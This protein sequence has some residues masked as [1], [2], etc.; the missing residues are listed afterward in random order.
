LCWPG[1]S[2]WQLPRR[3]VGG[4]DELDENIIAEH[5]PLHPLSNCVRLD[6]A[7]IAPSLPDLHQELKRMYPRAQHLAGGVVNR[8]SLLYT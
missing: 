3:E 8:H 5:L 7:K 1:R 6:R 4:P 2:V